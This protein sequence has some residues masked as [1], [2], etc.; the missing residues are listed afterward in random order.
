AAGVALAQDLRIDRR[1]E[2][3]L[4]R[5]AAD[6]DGFVEVDAVDAGLDFVLGDDDARR[7]AGDAGQ[8]FQVQ[9]GVHRLLRL[10][11]GG[12]VL[13]GGVAEGHRADVNGVPQA[14]AVAGIEA[15]A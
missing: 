8:P 15:V 13:R 5:F 2:P 6:A 10:L 4:V 1:A 14:V 12:R 3:N 9:H 11:A 7:V